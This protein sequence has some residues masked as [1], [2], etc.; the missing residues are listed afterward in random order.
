[1]WQLGRDGRPHEKAVHTGLTDGMF[2]EVVEGD[3][4]KGDAV[5]VAWAQPASTGAH[6]GPLKF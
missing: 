3:L 4:A 5:V 2:T 1:V 6:V